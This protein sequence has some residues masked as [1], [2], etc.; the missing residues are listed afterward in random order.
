MQV[1]FE[2]QAAGECAWCGGALAH[3]AAS[4]EREPVDS[5][6]GE[7]AVELDAEKLEC[8]AVGRRL[9]GDGFALFGEEQLAHL[10]SIQNA[11]LGDAETCG[12]L[13]GADGVKAC[14]LDAEIDR[15]RITGALFLGVGGFEGGSDRAQLVGL[16]RVASVPSRAGIRLPRR[17]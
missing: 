17:S 12:D 1:A 5:L 9:P 16:A 14:L 8:G 7:E 6:R 3:G 2:G 11:C 10:D 4:V 15:D 13:G